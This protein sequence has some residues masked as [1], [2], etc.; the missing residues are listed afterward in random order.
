MCSIVNN[1]HGPLVLHEIILSIQTVECWE[2]FSHDLS[3]YGAKQKEL[4][5]LDLISVCFRVGSRTFC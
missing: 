1:G 5:E 2:I 4:E 3:G